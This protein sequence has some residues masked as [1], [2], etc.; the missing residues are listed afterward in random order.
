MID[1]PISKYVRPLMFV[2]SWVLFTVAIL[3]DGNIGTFT[4]K[5]AYLPIIETLVV[6]ITIAY[7][8]SRGLEKTAQ[9]IKDNK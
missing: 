7:V 5:P 6:T 8:G 3:C 4:I 9:S 2:W 1:S